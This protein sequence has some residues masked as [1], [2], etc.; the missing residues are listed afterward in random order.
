MAST[1]PPPLIKRFFNGGPRRRQIATNSAA[2]AEALRRVGSEYRD[3]G[4]EQAG[5]GTLFEVT[6]RIYPLQITQFHA[7]AR[8]FAKSERMSDVGPLPEALDND[9]GVISI[10]VY[11]PTADSAVARGLSGVREALYEANLAIPSLAV[12]AWPVGST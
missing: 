11:A 4:R 1:S 10:Q 6:V 2:L 5:A 8:E 7:L 9:T 12:S 3:L